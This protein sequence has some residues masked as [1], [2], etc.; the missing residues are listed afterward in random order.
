MHWENVS[1][2]KSGIFDCFIH[3]HLDAQL[4]FDQYL[5]ISYSGNLRNL[6]QPIKFNDHIALLCEISIFF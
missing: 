3:K 5:I 6:V 4:L 2:M 1:S